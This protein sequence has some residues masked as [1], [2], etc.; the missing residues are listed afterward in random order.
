MTY[1]RCHYKRTYYRE[2]NKWNNNT[3]RIRH[4]SFEPI[5]INRCPNER[6][7]V[8]R[9]HNETNERMKRIP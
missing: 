2:V 3:L 8:H 1:D 6:D 5:H 9:V 4:S 7:I